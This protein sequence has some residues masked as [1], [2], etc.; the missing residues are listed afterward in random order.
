MMAANW[1][2][3]GLPTVQPVEV[4]EDVGLWNSYRQGTLL[5]Y[6]GKQVAVLF[7][8]V[9]SMPGINTYSDNAQQRT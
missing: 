2:Q 4:C 3:D 7:E 8:D 9:S 6:K 5:G 1:L